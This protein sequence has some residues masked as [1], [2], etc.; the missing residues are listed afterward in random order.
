MLLR[1]K[2][3]FE[4]FIDYGESFDFGRGHVGAPLGH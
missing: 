1:A 4:K 3:G 2:C